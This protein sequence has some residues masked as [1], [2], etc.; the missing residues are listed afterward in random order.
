MQTQGNSAISNLQFDMVSILHSKAEGLEAYDKYMKDAQGENS[1]PCV[2]LLQRLKRQDEEAVMEVKQHLTEL[3]QKGS[4]GSGSM[5]SG[6]S[7]SQMQSQ[8]SDRSNGR[9]TQ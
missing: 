4:M 2:E 6:M 8:G 7:S 9:M 5:Q 3:L 1:Q